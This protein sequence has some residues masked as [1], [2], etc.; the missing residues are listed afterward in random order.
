MT[1]TRILSVYIFSKGCL[2]KALRRLTAAVMSPVRNFT[3]LTSSTLA[4]KQ[5]CTKGSEQSWLSQRVNHFLF[6]FVLKKN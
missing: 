3:A 2:Y 4:F 6:C 1:V 5:L